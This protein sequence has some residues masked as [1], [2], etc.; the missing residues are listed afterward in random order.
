MRAV[1]KVLVVDDDPVIGKSFD[2]V[3]STKG[4]AVITAE[5]GA[6][7]LKK[8]SAEDYDVVYTD[9]RMP[10]M[11][12]LEVAEQVRA[13]RPW[14][15]VVIIT[16]Y[17]N[18]EHEARAKAAG[19]TAF[20]NKPLSPDMIEESAVVAL[21]KAGAAA[22]RETAPQQPSEGGAARTIRTLFSAALGGLAF[23][24]AFPVVALASLAWL[25]L[26]AS[27]RHAGIC[28]AAR[29][30]GNIG[31][32]LMSPF[33][34]GALMAAMPMVGVYA[35]LSLADKTVGKQVILGRARRKV[36]TI[37]R[38]LASPLTVIVGR[39]N[40]VGRAVAAPFIA[41]A[42]ILFPAIAAAMFVTVGLD[43]WISEPA[44]A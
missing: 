27:G 13:Q 6:E 16:G 5:N 12:G 17:G 25:G 34:A 37:G 44:A 35:L 32:L 10:G 43:A 28:S 33:I 14:T 39:D 21:R 3:L 38:T 40:M 24:I 19:V 4:Y 22:P 41:L 15:P 9:I 23:V 1:H 36:R 29:T 7:A 31:L 8:L 26:R 2:R 30:M 11:S 20:L 18:E 42:Y